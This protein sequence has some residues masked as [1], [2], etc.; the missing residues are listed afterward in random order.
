MKLTKEQIEHIRRIG[1]LVGL[2]EL[3]DMAL[4]ALDKRTYEQGLEDAAKIIAGAAPGFCGG[5]A[6]IVMYTCA[7]SIRAMKGTK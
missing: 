3:C 7:K 4:T 2:D 5:A 6:E 1:N